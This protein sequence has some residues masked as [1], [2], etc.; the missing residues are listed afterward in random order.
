F[1]NGEKPADNDPLWGI[2]TNWSRLKRGAAIGKI[3]ASVRDN[4]DAN[5]PSMSVP[6]LLEAFKL[7]Q[8]LEDNYWR[9]VKTKDIKEV[10]KACLGMYLEAAASDY[11]ATK[12][13]TIELSMEAINRSDAPVT[14][15]S[16][17]YL[18]MGLDS[19]VNTQLEKNQGFSF[20]KSLKI[21]TNMPSTTP[22]WLNKDASLGMYSVPD[23]TLRGLP[24]TPRQFR[25]KYVLDIAG[26]AIDYE[27]EVVFKKNDPVKGETYRPFEFIPPVSVAIA[28]KVFLYPNDEAQIVKVV[29]KAGK[30][31]AAGVITLEIP[32]G[33]KTRIEAFKYDLQ[34]K[35]EE[36]T[37][38]FELIPPKNQSVGEIKKKKKISGTMEPFSDEMIVMEYDHIPTQTILMPAT[39]KV[40]RVDLKKK[41]EKIGYIMGAGD[42]IPESL[43]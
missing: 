25:V 15:K 36:K 1:I 3:L 12:G 23:Q 24:S 42:A 22:Y 2:N 7:I 32:E 9:E 34:Q 6:K 21:P 37:F 31:N 10:I 17:Q 27:T 30:E 20:S 26:T 39:S 19:S 8:K 38:E 13:Q 35:G 28:E 11:S 4:F 29:V 18:P 16:V 40:V 41:G 33:W 5:D 43:E 14:L